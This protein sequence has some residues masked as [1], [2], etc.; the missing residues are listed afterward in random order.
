M[1]QPAWKAPIHDGPNA[2]V[3]PIVV[4]LAYES[5]HVICGLFYL[6][7]PAL[8]SLKLLRLKNSSCAHID[9]FRRQVKV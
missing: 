5:I 2:S 1:F 6:L 8:A 7:L 4:P 9:L 3:A